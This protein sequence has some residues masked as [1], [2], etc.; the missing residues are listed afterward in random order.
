MMK[1]NAI[2]ISLLSVFTLLL[3]SCSSQA[4][5][6]PKKIPSS[7]IKQS[8][9]N[10]WSKFGDTQ[11][12]FMQG[13]VG[14][15]QQEPKKKKIKENFCQCALS[16][17]KIRYAPQLFLQINNVSNQLGQNGPVL[18]NLMMKPELDSCSAQTNYHP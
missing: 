14:Q 5:N 10:D 15:Q 1:F 7:K 8:V 4:Q 17:Y 6:S 12:Q 16:A 9:N 18:V 13:C 11:A 3:A 2:A